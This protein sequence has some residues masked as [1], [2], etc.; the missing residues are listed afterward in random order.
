MAPAGSARKSSG[1]VDD[2]AI[3]PT[4]SG[5]PVSS[6]IAH[7]AATAWKNVPMFENTAAVHS[8]RKCRMCSGP[9]EDFI[10]MSLGRVGVGSA[11]RSR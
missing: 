1:S 2:A 4:H 8:A 7:E 10:D 11:R 6:S 5:E 9:M 3:S